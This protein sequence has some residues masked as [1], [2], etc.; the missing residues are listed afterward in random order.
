VGNTSL[1]V[2]VN[3]YIEDMYQDLREHTIKG[4]FTFVAVDENREP[5]KVWTQE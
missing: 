3:I 1:K 2:E 4:V 5:T